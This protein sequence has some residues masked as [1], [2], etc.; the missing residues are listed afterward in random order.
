M[1]NDVGKKIRLM[2]ESELIN[3]KQLS[4]LT[5]IPYTSLVYYESDKNSPDVQVVM[6]ILNHPRFTKY[7]LWF[8]TNQ[9]A[10]EAGQIAPVLAHFGQEEGD[11]SLSDQK[12]G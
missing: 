9:I 3:R 6:K 12:I 11:S 4:D 8:M 1:S 2:R 10:P 5:G 7:T